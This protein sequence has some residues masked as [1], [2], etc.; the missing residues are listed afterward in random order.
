MEESALP[1]IVFKQPQH[2]PLLEYSTW[3]HLIGC[4]CYLAD[5]FPPSFFDFSF[6]VCWARWCQHS[7]PQLNFAWF[8]ARI[9]RHLS[10]GPHPTPKNTPKKLM[11]QI[12]PQSHLLLALHFF[13]NICMCFVAWQ[14]WQNRTAFGVPLRSNFCCCCSGIMGRIAWFC[15][16]FQD[17]Q[18]WTEP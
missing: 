10:H 9:S 6:E 2:Q 15:P 16:R 12:L 3:L 8:A 5:R 11:Y 1:A 14:L 17:A 7:H 4:S 13:A 18:M